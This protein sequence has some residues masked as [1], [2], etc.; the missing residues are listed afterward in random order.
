MNKHEADEKIKIIESLALEIEL[1]EELKLID[2]RYSIAAKWC[3]MD[4]ESVSLE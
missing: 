1:D 2:G 4:I 3:D